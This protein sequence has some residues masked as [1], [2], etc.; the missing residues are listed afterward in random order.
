MRG[1]GI[2]R[3]VFIH[4]HE[5]AKFDFGPGH[6]YKPERAI[7]A[8]ELCRRYGVMDRPW[9]QTITPK[10]IDPGLLS[11]F[12]DEKYLDL[13]RQA[14]AGK[15][16]LD[17]L[18]HGIGSED[19]PILPG[20]YEWSLMTAGATHMGMRFIVEGEADVAFNPL[21]GFHH[22]QR[23]YA[24]GFCYVNDV[25]IAITD[26]MKR[27]R[28]VAFID[29]DAH[30]CNGVQDAFYEENRV[31]VVSLHEAGETLYPGTGK[32]DEIGVGKG[33]GYTVNIPLAEGTD[34]E[35]YVS[36]F[37][38]V[39]PPI[40]RAFEPDFV[41]AEIG[42]DTLRSDPLTH[43]MLTNNAYQEVVKS[44]KGFSKHLL[45]LGGG[46]YD[47]YRTARCWTLAW[48]ILN[49]VEPEDEFAGVVGG[50]MFGPEMEVSS[51]YDAP[52][53]STGEVKERALAKAK[54]AVDFFKS[55]V[56]PI[57]GIKG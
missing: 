29:I 55:N 49:E 53:P 25:A 44:I 5:L 23:D 42:A 54:E 4:S 10:P 38:E 47:I 12:H 37:Q 45:S 30:H 32:V 26:A 33:V 40:I 19:N 46:G 20:I 21:G 39:V 41:V 6:P 2:V 22:A 51:L 1:T 24:E 27:G 9:M 52:R 34:D 11:L 31:L 7:K 3:S 35:V 17:M 56:F 14:S 18:A 43:L 28:K 36:V 8:Y 16:T 48:S 57:H 13:L 50:M 15:V